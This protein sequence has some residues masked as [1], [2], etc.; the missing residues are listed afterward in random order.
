MQKCGLMP[1]LTIVERR[2]GAD[3]QVEGNHW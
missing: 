1:C 3:D 2:V